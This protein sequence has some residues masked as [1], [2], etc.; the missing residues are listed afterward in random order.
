MN[1]ANKIRRV[2]IKRKGCLL[3][4]SMAVMFSFLLCF[5][6]NASLIFAAEN[7]SEHADFQPDGKHICKTNP[8]DTLLLAENG[9]A[10]AEIVVVSRSPVTAFAAR[11]LKAFLDQATGADFK[12]VP[13]RTGDLPAIFVGDSVWARKWGVDV[14]KLARDG[15]VIRR[16]KDAIIIAGKDDP[17]VDPEKDRSFRYERGTIFGVYDFLER[18][19]GVRF[20]FPGEIGTVVPKSPTL[21]VPAMD[22]LESPDFSIRTVSW[23]YAGWFFKCDTDE[24]RRQIRLESLRLR[25]Q[26][27]YIP[28]CHGLS[29][30]GYFDRFGETHPEFFILR[31]DG[32]RGN[33]KSRPGHLGQLCYSNTN[34]KEEVYKDAEAFLTG[35]PASSRGMKRKKYKKVL[36]PDG[37]FWDW[38]ACMP[39]YFNA[40]PQD[41][42]EPCYCPLCRPFLE[43][44]Q[45][46]DL[47]WEFVC[48][49]ARKLKKNGIPG[50]ITNTAYSY[51]IKVPDMEIPDNVLV[52]LCTLGPLQYK[53]PA[54]QEQDD[55]LI[56]DWH[57]KL[58][59]KTELR[60][61]MTN[62]G[63]RVPSGIPL[64]STKWIAAYYKRNAPHIFGAFIESENDYFLCQYLNWYVFMKIA[65]DVSTDENKLMAEHNQKL[66]GPAAEPMG[67]F[68]SR[69]EELWTGELVGES[70]NTSLG[71][72]T[73]RPSELK[74]W[75][76]VYN[77]ERLTELGN[78]IDQA[79]KL[80]ANDPDSLKRVKF[81]REKMLGVILKEREIYTQRKRE[82]EDL[83]FEVTP[84]PE[85]QAITVDGILNE[86]A[87]QTA[88]EV[89][90]VPHATDK[91]AL[92]KTRVRVLW[93]EKNL[94]LAF[95][96]EEPKTN[97]ISVFSRQRDDQDIWKDSSV[98]IFLNPSNDRANYFQF[99]VNAKGNLAD[100]AWRMKDKVNIPD[101]GWNVNAAAVARIEKG[102]WI[103]EIAIPME[104]VVPNGIK[105]GDT[106]VAN[107]NRSRYVRNGK[108]EENQLYTWSP[109]VKGGFHKLDRFG[110]MRFVREKGK[111]KI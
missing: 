32:S 14:G 43:K 76:K 108:S 60:N 75:E 37:A 8:E 84:L 70:K 67:R 36:P 100:L 64:I 91:P 69:L 4:F 98:E 74:T 81:F 77:E 59:R 53:T 33:D 30:L 92:V 27:I 104:E 20:Y 48:D 23:G 68:F 55:Q 72:T 105:A 90:L 12:I 87:W 102:T 107:F 13:R 42:M 94:Y 26:T 79:E 3:R 99:I 106:M 46:G 101:W 85:G 57:A 109:F 50:Y 39:G 29:R 52:K 110:R 5:L 93:T 24:L 28:N 66:F 10:N 18:F 51:Y 73:L 25:R 61:Y 71:P 44:K 6:F 9:K 17:F 97:S 41:G 58:K 22:I 45:V 86:P 7:P 21:R 40:M 31:S 15:F 34:L 78:Y 63:K 38:N 16:M 1:V 95:D 49:L 103:A 96:C 54:F 82:I 35:K 80:A 89:C 65:W 19:L 83:V 111:K 88:Q 56:R 47:V 62:V 2:T 11:E